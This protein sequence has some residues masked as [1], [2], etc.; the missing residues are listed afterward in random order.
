MINKKFVLPCH[1]LCLTTW[2]TQI[3]I[4]QTRGKGE[5]KVYYNYSNQYTNI[6]GQDILATIIEYL[7][8][9]DLEHLTFQKNL[10]HKSSVKN[11]FAYNIS[12]RRNTALTRDDSKY[13]EHLLI[14]N[15]RHAYSIIECLECNNS[16]IKV[17]LDKITQYANLL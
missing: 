6:G 11:I 7:Q 13:I 2:S 5:R 10:L 15:F 17:S 14:H 4:S 16:N 1:G 9:F 12:D 8:D 3:H